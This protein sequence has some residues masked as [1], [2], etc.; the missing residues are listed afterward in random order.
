[1]ADLTVIQSAALASEISLAKNYSIKS[2]N[3][4]N[5]L[6]SEVNTLKTDLATIVLKLQNLST[7]LSQGD[8]SGVSSSSLQYEN[9]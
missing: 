5:D 9:L 4:V 1:M 6:T 2:N 3:L 7:L 8:I